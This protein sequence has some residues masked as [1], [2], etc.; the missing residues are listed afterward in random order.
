MSPKIGNEDSGL[1]LGGRILILAFWKLLESWWKTHTATLTVTKTRGTSCFR[2]KLSR[3]L[4]VQ[5]RGAGT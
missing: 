2:V 5:R 3:T 1:I 4:E